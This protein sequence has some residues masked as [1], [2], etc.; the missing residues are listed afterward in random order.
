MK[1]WPFAL[2]SLSSVLVAAAE[3][4]SGD[5]FEQ[6][7]SAFYAQAKADRERAGLDKDAAK[8][9]YPTPE[10]RLGSSDP[11]RCAGAGRDRR[12]RLHREAARRE[13]RR[14]HLRAAGGA[15]PQGRRGKISAKVRAGK[16]A[17]PRQCRLTA[18]SATSA[19]RSDFPAVRIAGKYVWELQLGNGWTTR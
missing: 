9:R 18:A 10:L 13:P 2:A 4:A 3:Q 1:R 19:I 16:A 15:G 8:A 7:L 17:L 11:E 14:L 12:A 5:A 6:R